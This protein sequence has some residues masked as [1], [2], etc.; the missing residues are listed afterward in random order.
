[1]FHLE[2]EDCG[3]PREHVALKNNTQHWSNYRH[4][5]PPAEFNISPHILYIFKLAQTASGNHFVMQTDKKK[6]P[7]KTANVMSY[8]CPDS[9]LIGLCGPCVGLEYNNLSSRGTSPPNTILWMINS[10]STTDYQPLLLKLNV[11]A[12]K[13]IVLSASSPNWILSVH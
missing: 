6:T 11:Q 1:M 4:E 13:L 7:K 12:S 5:H 2:L 10:L 9:L 8:L 3:L